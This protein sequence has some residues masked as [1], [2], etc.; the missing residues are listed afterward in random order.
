MQRYA[1]PL[2]DGTASFLVKS[3]PGPLRARGLSR[4]PTS[5]LGRRGG[6]SAPG[7]S[8]SILAYARG[9]FHL[10][11]R[12]P[13]G[14]RRGLPQSPP[15]K[16]NAHGTHQRHF[17]EERSHTRGGTDSKFQERE[18]PDRALSPPFIA[19]FNCQRPPR[20]LCAGYVLF[21]RR[22]GSGSSFRSWRTTSRPSFSVRP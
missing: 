20:Q 7:A 2:G 6:L 3:A 15:H 17:R 10:K 19:L 18:G 13:S 12:A 9:V 11:M 16:A 8:P 21:V 22:V 14:H 1:L 4:S 5:P